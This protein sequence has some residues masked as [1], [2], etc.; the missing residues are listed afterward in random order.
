VISGEPT[1]QAYYV[2]GSNDPIFSV[3]P[4]ATCMY[5]INITNVFGQA[6]EI[7]FFFGDCL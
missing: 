7:E 5:D 1:N 3:P 4:P 6:M 2:C